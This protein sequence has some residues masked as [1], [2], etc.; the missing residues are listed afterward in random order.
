LRI[1]TRVRVAV[2]II[3]LSCLAGSAEA[4][5]TAYPTD[6]QIGRAIEEVSG[7]AINVKD[8]RVEACHGS[9]EEPTEF[10][11]TWSQRV[12]GRWRR[13]NGWFYIDATGWHS[14]C[15]TGHSMECFGIR[16]SVR[17]IE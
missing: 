12:A 10:E 11:C 14:Q 5:T 3:A 4:Q 8:L 7:R 6:K 16:A 13:Q 17:P 9:E 1:K 2:C 15:P